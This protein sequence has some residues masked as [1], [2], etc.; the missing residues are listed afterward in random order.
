[1]VSQTVRLGRQN[2]P[3]SLEDLMS[4]M[5]NAMPA[6]LPIGRFGRQRDVAR[7]FG[8]TGMIRSRLDCER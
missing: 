2:K 3:P 5:S 7:F 6:M 1:M 4:T 8:S